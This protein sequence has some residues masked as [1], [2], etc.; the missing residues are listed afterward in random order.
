MLTIC[1][2]TT[3]YREHNDKIKKLINIDVSAETVQRYETSYRHTENFIKKYYNRED[4][5]SKY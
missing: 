1:Q 4:S 3:I 5:F 2:Q